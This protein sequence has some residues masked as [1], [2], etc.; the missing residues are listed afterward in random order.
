M[1][2]SG[3]LKVEI[4]RLSC[5]Q[6]KHL[7]RIV[8]KTPVTAG[9]PKRNSLSQNCMNQTTVSFFLYSL[10]LFIDRKHRQLSLLCK[11]LDKIARCGAPFVGA[12]MTIVL[13]SSFWCLMESSWSVLFVEFWRVFHLI[14]EF[15]WLRFFLYFLLFG[16]WIQGTLHQIEATVKCLRSQG[17]KYVSHFSQQSILD[18]CFL[19]FFWKIENFWFHFFFK[20]WFLIVFEVTPESM[21]C[22][23]FT[24]FLFDSLLDNKG[25]LD[26][27]K[28]WE[29]AFFQFFSFCEID[30]WKISYFC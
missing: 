11:R 27:E 6:L 3:P 29:N 13:D 22:T 24:V 7:V 19:V 14:F 5:Q 26:V 23:D 10:G 9:E 15:F 30:S 2:L 8:F 16:T 4:S 17:F 1:W 25:L 21:K 28:T 20:L 18:L 12:A